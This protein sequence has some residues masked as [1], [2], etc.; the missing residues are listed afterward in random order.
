MTPMNN[1]SEITKENALKAYKGADDCAKKVL[2]D[3]FGKRVFVEDTTEIIKSV[4]DALEFL[5][6]SDE[7]VQELRK[8]EKADLS[9]RSLDR[10]RL[11]LVIK[12]LNGGKFNTVEDIWYYPY[13]RRENGKLS[14]G[15]GY[16]N[17]NGVVSARLTLK[18]SKLAIYCGEQFIKLYNKVYLP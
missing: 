13:F 7:D 15:G 18:N 11:E 10:Q 2:E 4:E 1:K 6:E 5:G 8:M 16:W 9:E 17:G 3:I 12:A 14:F